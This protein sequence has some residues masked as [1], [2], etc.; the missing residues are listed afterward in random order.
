MVK[1]MGYPPASLGLA[2]VGNFLKQQWVWTWLAPLGGVP[3]SQLDLVAREPHV[4]SDRLEE[5]LARRMWTKDN[6]F[7]YAYIAGKW[8]TECCPRYMEE[9]HYKA[10]KVRTCAGVPRTVYG[11]PCTV[12]RVWCIVY[13]KI[14]TVRTPLDSILTLAP[15]S[16]P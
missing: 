3:K 16:L 2:T 11:V 12:Y 14:F 5:V 7:Y 8:S 1:Q 10:L 4:W 15:P 13:G 6:Y 9:K